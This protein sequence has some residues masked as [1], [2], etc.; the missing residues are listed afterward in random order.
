MELRRRELLEWLGRTATF[1][2][3]GPLVAAC[4]RVAASGDGQDAGSAAATWLVAIRTR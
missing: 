4:G 2:L 3:A 1:A